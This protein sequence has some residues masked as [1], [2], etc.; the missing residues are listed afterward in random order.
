MQAGSCFLTKK[1]CLLSRANLNTQTAAAFAKKYCLHLSADSIG[2]P[3]SSPECIAN[4]RQLSLHS[5]LCPLYLML[6]QRQLRPIVRYEFHLASQGH[7]QRAPKQTFS[8]CVGVAEVLPPICTAGG[9]GVRQRGC[10]CSS[11]SS[12]LLGS[13]RRQPPL[14]LKLKIL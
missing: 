10:L 9:A 12:N 14:I 2:N 5:S 6:D 13:W 3:F 1:Y 8:C 4:A 7:A 11:R